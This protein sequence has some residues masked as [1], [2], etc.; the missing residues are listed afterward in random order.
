M[1]AKQF[2]TYIPGCA[3]GSYEC[4]NWSETIFHYSG[5]LAQMTGVQRTSVDG[6]ASVLQKNGL[7]SYKRGHTDVENIDRVRASAC[8]CHGTLRSHFS[9]EDRHADANRNESDELPFSLGETK[10]NP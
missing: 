4:M 2:M 10:R 1:P 3:S 5:F 7:I 9:S 6:V 8:K